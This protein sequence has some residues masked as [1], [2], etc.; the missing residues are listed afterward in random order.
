[1]E[2]IVLWIYDMHMA[3]PSIVWNPLCQ[4]TWIS[5]G[6]DFSIYVTEYWVFPEPWLFG[7]EEK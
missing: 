5:G 2:W 4:R 6:E 3:I 1:M 7:E